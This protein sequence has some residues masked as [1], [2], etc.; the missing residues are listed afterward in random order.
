MGDEPVLG[1]VRTTEFNV[2]RFGAGGDGRQKDTSA[3]QRAID[4]CHQEGGGVVY[5]PP[6]TYLS[7]T[8]FLKS[9]VELHLEAGAKLRGSAEREDYVARFDG[10]TWTNQFNYDQYLLSAHK[11]RN[12]AISG[13][14]TIDGRGTAFFGPK[15]EGERHRTVRGWRPGPLLA[16]INCEDVLL[17]D[18]TLVDSPAFSVWT[19]G[20]ER[21]RITGVTIDNERDVPNADGIHIGSC[22]DVYI[23]NSTISAGDDCIAVF[24]TSQFQDHVRTCAHVM[25]TNC[26][27]TTPCNGIRVGFSSDWPIRDCTFSNI[28]MHN[29]RTG[30]SMLCTP[31]SSGWKIEGERE[32]F[33]GPSIEGISFNNIRM[34]TRRPFFFWVDP[35]AKKPAGIRRVCLSNVDATVERGAYIGGVESAPIEDVSIR[36]MVLRINGSMPEDV[37]EGLSCPYPQY[38]WHTA[39]IPHALFCRRVQGLEIAGSRLDWEGATGSW[40]S[41]VRVEQVRDLRLVRMT[42]ASSPVVAAAPDLFLYDVEDALIQGCRSAARSGAFLRVAGSHT[43]NVKLLGNDL[44]EAGDAWSTSDETPP[45]AVHERGNLLPKP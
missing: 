32:A 7:G 20:C 38:D 6:G 4:A 14:G 36:D 41:G 27:L 37:P 33:S 11:A 17:R 13:R 30:I 28:V 2:R 25:V 5:F 19:V 18:I 31:D 1:T 15:R 22:Q 3:I 35:A 8:L 45:A 40:R 21:V 34:E 12:V 16:F 23:A 9:N 24:S 26:V 10:G 29:T 44:S 42:T 39:G 43:A